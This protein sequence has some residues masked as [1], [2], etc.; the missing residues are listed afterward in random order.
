[1][2]LSIETK[3]FC[4]IRE[5]TKL[6][7]SGIEKEGEQ[8][9]LSLRRLKKILL[10]DSDELPHHHISKSYPPLENLEPVFTNESLSYAPRVK[11]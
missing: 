7:K 6:S 9:S 2:N 4:S 1:M 3:N 10:S 11:G 5:T 8:A